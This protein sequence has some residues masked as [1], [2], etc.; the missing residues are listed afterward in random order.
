MRA[1][2]IVNTASIYG[3]VAGPRWGHYVASKHGVIGLTKTAAIEYSDQRIRVN[4]V[5]PTYIK[6]P[7]ITNAIN[8]QGSARCC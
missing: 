3:F 7:M 6:T 2:A 5:C 8:Q 1:L 4:A